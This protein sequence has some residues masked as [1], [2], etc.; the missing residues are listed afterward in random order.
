MAIAVPDEKS[1]Q[2]ET[3]C[4]GLQDGAVV[5]EETPSNTS[6]Q[7]TEQKTDE[8]VP[9]S[10]SYPDDISVAAVPLCA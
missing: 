5:T 4:H 9:V 6:D 2:P 8:S 7:K 1:E 3:S 10:F